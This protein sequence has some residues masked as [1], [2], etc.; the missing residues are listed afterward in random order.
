MEN[1]NKLNENQTE[2]VS[3]GVMV[4]G[5]PYVRINQRDIEGHEYRCRTCGYIGYESKNAEPV[6]G[7]CPRCQNAGKY[8]KTGRFYMDYNKCNAS[9]TDAYYYNQ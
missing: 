5:H 3:G 7:T 6:T 2:N 8:Q 9:A 1:N 4:D